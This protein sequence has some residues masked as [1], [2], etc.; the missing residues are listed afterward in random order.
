MKSATIQRTL[1]EQAATFLL[2]LPHKE[3]N[4]STQ[5]SRDRA[6]PAKTAR[7]KN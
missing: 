6:Q 4:L 3:Q 7:D 1:V 5:D 2:A